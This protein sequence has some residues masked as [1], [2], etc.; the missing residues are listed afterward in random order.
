MEDVPYVLI[1]AAEAHRTLEAGGAPQLVDVREASEIQALSVEGA[2]NLPLSRLGELAERL[3]RNRP[4]F[5]LCR[6][7]NRAASAAAQLRSLGHRDVLVIR[8]GLDA[9]VKSGKPYVRGTSRV[10]S[11]E[12]QVRFAAGGL[13]L[14]GSVLAFAVDPRWLALPAFVGLGL[15]FAA[16]TDTCGIARVL[17]RMPWNRGSSGPGR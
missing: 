8:G 4:I 9:W 3:D 5:L 6:S 14:T 7:G 17:A 15:V 11:L 1:E 10:W 12:R 2:L 16:A 13:V